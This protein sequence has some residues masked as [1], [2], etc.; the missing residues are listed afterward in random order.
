MIQVLKGEDRG[1]SDGDW[2]SRRKE[3]QQN[4]NKTVDRR[5]MTRGG[6]GKWMERLQGREGGDCTL[7]TAHM[8]RDACKMWV[9]DNIKNN[10]WLI[11]EVVKKTTGITEKDA[12]CISDIV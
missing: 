3:E 1:G 6:N 9:K 2:H 8:N 4:N 12:I 5:R 10:G 7:R 11:N